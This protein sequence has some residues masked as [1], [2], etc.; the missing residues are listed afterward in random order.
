M[1]D[2][3]INRREFGSLTAAGLTGAML[4]LSA[5]LPAAE[6]TIETWDPDKPPVVTGRPFAC[7][8][9]WPTA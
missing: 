9:F 8:P 2:H 6:A 1:C 7:S 4:G 3:C 5:A